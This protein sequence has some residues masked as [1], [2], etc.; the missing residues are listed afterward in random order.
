M[1]PGA[2]RS[3]R[4][5]PARP[6]SALLLLGLLA[7]SAALAAGLEEA[8]KLHR[9]GRLE[10]ALVAY[11]AV[12]VEAA[13]AGDLEAAGTARNNACVLLHDRG[14]YRPAVAE[15]E[16]ALELRRAAGDRRRLAR[17]LNNL[18]LALQSVG[19]LDD[20][21]AAYEEALELNHELGDAEGEVVNV[22][23]L[24]VLAT[25]AGRY[26]EA[27]RRHAEAAERAAAAGEAPW[28]RSQLATAGLNRGVVLER[29]GAFEEALALYARLLAAE[30]AL[31]PRQRASLLINSGVVYRNLGD[32]VSA[33]G[34]FEAAAALYR[35]AGD[36]AGLA[37]AALNRA[38]A[39]ELDL[40]RPA[41]AE[42]AYRQALELAVESGDR[43]E[44]IRVRYALGRVVLAGGR[45][46]EAAALFGRSL[47]LAEDSGDVEGRWSALEGLGRVARGRGELPV[48]LQRLAPA[49]ELIESQ[50][51][52]LE[53]GALR[54]GYFGDKRAV[55]AAAVSIHAE[56]ARGEPSGGHAEAALELVQR[57]KARDLLDALG[58]HAGRRAAPGGPESPSKDARPR[59][60]RGEGAAGEAASAESFQVAGTAAGTS[61]PLTVAELQARLGDAGLLE[62]FAGDGELFLW[63]VTRDGVE[64]VEL[65]ASGPVLERVGSLHRRLAA[66]GEPPA[67]ELAEL[68]RTLLPAATGAWPARRIFYVAPDGPLHY[69][70]FELLASPD[71]R[72][73]PLVERATVSYLPSGSALQPSGSERATPAVTRPAAAPESTA[74]HAAAGRPPRVLAGFGAPRLADAA[75]GPGSAAATLAVRFGLTPLPGALAELETAASL[76][77][78]GHQLWTGERATEAAFRG[79]VERGARVVH[80][81]THTV[82]D[83]LSSRGAA[84]L[85]TPAGGDDGLLYADEI[86]RLDYRARLTVLAACRSAAGAERGRAL[87]TLTGAVLAAGS[88]AVVATLWDVGDVVAAGFMEQFYF[89]LGRGRPPAEALRRAKQRLRADPRWRAPHLWAG[90]VL[91]GAAPPVAGPGWRRPRAALLA[92][93]AA[94]AVLAWWGWRR[95]P[96]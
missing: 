51:A 38:L 37:N 90:Y 9:Q 79:A 54:A 83:E 1:G 96:G 75:G 85:L 6:A 55:Y 33:L 56:L 86:A 91:V 87:T 73:T 42:A 89:Q 16:A 34:R 69:L 95:R 31:D 53:R 61:H 11:R 2:G 44:E 17:T 66:G 77:P 27:L 62:Y 20:A 50:R 3:P 63:I 48:A 7:G 94:A 35:E 46:A 29:L 74:A 92:G 40:E 88:P 76:L 5:R 81:A 70:P 72:G 10:E 36:R 67:A 8:R 78:G 39:L 26:D 57:A 71:H 64:L 93:L 58:P 68:S 24:G 52:T 60:S 19:R 14:D 49:L 30:G 45:P 82:L 4:R 84:V 25:L 22:A 59:A 41:E 13:A 80:L 47:E 18:G 28:T 12:A 43:A 32:P 21:A 15:C 23:N 65:G